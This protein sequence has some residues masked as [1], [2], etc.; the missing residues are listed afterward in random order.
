MWRNKTEQLLK[1]LEKNTIYFYF[2]ENDWR[3]LKFK[4]NAIVRIYKIKNNTCTCESFI[5]RG[6]CK[7]LDML[8][9]QPPALDEDKQQMIQIFLS[10]KFGEIIIFENYFLTGALNNGNMIMYPIFFNDGTKYLVRL[11]SLDRL[12]EIENENINI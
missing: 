2:K 7:H 1:K 11:E 3:I 10:E 6:Q 5:Y 9:Y 8:Y 4:D 12:K